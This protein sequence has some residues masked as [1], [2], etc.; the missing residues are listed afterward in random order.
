MDNPAYLFL[1]SQ[2]IWV[3][4][5]TL[6]ICTRFIVQH[7][8]FLPFLVSQPHLLFMNWVTGSAF[9]SYTVSGIL[10]WFSLPPILQF[11]HIGFLYLLFKYSWLAL[12]IFLGCGPWAWLICSCD[13]LLRHTLCTSCILVFWFH[14]SMHLKCKPKQKRLCF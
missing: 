5:L 13:K 11:H 7:L 4:L 10:F 12:R 3:M 9:L 8:R 2:H 1:S 6:Y 14:D